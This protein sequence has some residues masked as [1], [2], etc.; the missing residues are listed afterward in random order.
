MTKQKKFN[1]TL[2]IWTKPKFQTIKT[3]KRQHRTA[4]TNKLYEHKKHQKQQIIKPF[5][6]HKN[7]PYQKQTQCLHCKVEAMKIVTFQSKV[8]NFATL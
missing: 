8:L 1:I 5:D 7:H 4:S 6:T 3:K 2:K